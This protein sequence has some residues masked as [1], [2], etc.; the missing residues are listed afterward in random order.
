MIDLDF[1][2]AFT[3]ALA[4]FT[5][6][7]LFNLNAS[8]PF[9]SRMFVRDNGEIG[10]PVNVFDRVRRLVGAYRITTENGIVFW[11]VYEPRMAV[12]RCP[13]CLSFWV[14]FVGSVSYAFSQDGNPVLFHFALAF[15]VS[16]LVFLHLYVSEHLYV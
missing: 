15:C 10:H 1:L 5:K 4:Y 2:L 8:G 7:F 16:F 3:L 13:T 12:W 11:D 14:S 6:I 9:E